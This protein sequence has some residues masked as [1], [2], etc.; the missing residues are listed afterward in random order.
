MEGRLD[1]PRRAMQAQR[2]DA[3]PFPSHHNINY[4]ADFLYCAFGRAYGLLA[5]FDAQTSILA[6]VDGGRPGRRTFGDNPVYTGWRCDNDYQAV[7]NPPPA[8]FPRLSPVR[9]AGPVVGRESGGLSSL[10][11][12]SPWGRNKGGGKLA[13]RRE[14]AQPLRPAASLAGGAPAISAFDTTAAP[15]WRGC[16]GELA[17]LFP[18]RRG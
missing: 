2:I 13:G 12:L 10:R 8:D 1:K 7:R 11:R 9:K 6:K 5:H 18:A 4:H 3:A 16:N 17:G 15:F 14:E